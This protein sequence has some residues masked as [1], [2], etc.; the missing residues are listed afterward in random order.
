MSPEVVPAI[1]FPTLKAGTGV[2]IFT[3]RLCDGLNARG[4]RAEITWLPLRAEY[5]P[6]SVQAPQP[7]DWANIVHVDTRLHGRFLAPGLPVVATMHLCV[8][9]PALAAFKSHAQA[10]Y[11]R[12]WVKRVE[13]ATL[14]RASDVLAVSRYT[15]NMTMQAFDM[16]RIRVIPNGVPIPEGVLRAVERD[17]GN[18]F[19]LLYVGNWSRRKGVE[20][21]GPIMEELGSGYELRYTA[22]AHGAHV[23]AKLPANCM[24]I[25]RLDQQQVGMEYHDADALLFPSRLE[26]LPLTV[27]EAMAHGLLAVA[28]CSSSVPEIIEDGV[29]GMLFEVDDVAEAVATIKQL[30]T[31][32]GRWREMR[33]RARGKIENNFGFNQMV[34]AYEAVYRAVLSGAEVR[35]L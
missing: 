26:G 16:D 1:W 24:C 32:H 19:R 22:D 17:P 18:P 13:R 29:D 4:L 12:F 8:H 28:A 11:Q 23:N 31:D 14:S 2:D 6:W 35:R 7:P 20:L 25:G 10:F 34:D 9:D 27:I 30:S 33:S 21:L 3:E 5:L 15:A